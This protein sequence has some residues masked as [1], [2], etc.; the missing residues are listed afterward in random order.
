MSEAV[1]RG[2]SGKVYRFMALRPGAPSLHEPAV[3]AFARPGPL[4]KGWTPV[5]LSRT[6]DLATRLDGHERW[7]EA[8]L[9]GA[10]HVLALFE[11]ERVAREEA[12][13]DLVA[14]LK[15]ALNQGDDAADA[16]VTAARRSAEVV[17]F[18]A[19]PGVVFNPP[20]PVRA[21]G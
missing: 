8:E 19:R 9:L 18:P 17:A 5:F 12:E 3:Y 16:L 7:A 11:P 2:V 1:F 6:A 20:I 21:A 13:D 4:G 14:A 15:P 10:T